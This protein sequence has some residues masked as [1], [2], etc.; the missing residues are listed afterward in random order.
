L[1]YSKKKK[2]DIEVFSQAK[3][4]NKQARNED[5]FVILPGFAYAVIDGVSDKTGF[6]YKGK[7]G[8]EVAGRLVE[9][10]IRQANKS[11]NFEDIEA[12]WLVGCLEKNFQEIYAEIG[13]TQTTDIHA[14]MWFGAQLVLALEGQSSFR[15]IIIGDCGLRINGQEVFLFNNPIDDICTSIRKA[16]W[17]YLDTQ[18]VP[19]TKKNEIARAY[20]VSGLGSVIPKWSDWID[21]DALKIL[22][23]ITFKDLKHIQTKIDGLIVKKAILGGILEQS[24]YI[25]RIHPLGFP[26]I[27]GFPIPRDLVKQFDYKTEDIETI[28]LFSDGYFGYPKGTQIKDWEKYFKHIEFADP[29][30]VGDYASTKGSYDGKFADD[31]TILILHSKTQT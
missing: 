13:T 1:F 3:D 8:G 28:E 5:R 30:K 24:L 6:R 11:K 16:V 10:V 7:T 27:N 22:K 17:N 26:C 29:E 20:T 25:N 15:F 19:R 9:E 14:A 4:P 18:R 31:R 21:E 12:D 23:E 2:F